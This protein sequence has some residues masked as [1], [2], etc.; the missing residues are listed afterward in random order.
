LIY[1]HCQTIG[2]CDVHDVCGACGN[3]LNAGANMNYCVDNN[4]EEQMTRY[5]NNLKKSITRLNE[6]C[7]ANYTI[8]DFCGGDEK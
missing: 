8:D 6:L 7:L 1:L 4:Y 2:N 5:K 3:I